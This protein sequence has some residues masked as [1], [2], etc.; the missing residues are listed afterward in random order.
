[1]KLRENKASVMKI[2]LSNIFNIILNWKAVRQTCYKNNSLKAQ[3]TI[4]KSQ[5]ND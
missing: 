4:L 5:N 2:K 1:M 3:H